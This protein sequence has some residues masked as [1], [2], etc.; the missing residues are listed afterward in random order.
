MR[1]VIHLFDRAS[2]LSINLNKST[3]SPINVVYPI[4][5]I[6]WLLYGAIIWEFL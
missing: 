2:R 1:N 4:E 5:L 6:G 3:I